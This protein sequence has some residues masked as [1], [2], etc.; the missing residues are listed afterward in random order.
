MIENLHCGTLGQANQALYIPFGQEVKL[1]GLQETNL[2][3]YMP[4]LTEEGKADT[5]EALRSSILKMNM[6]ELQ[7]DDRKH[8]KHSEDQWEKFF[9][10]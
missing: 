5:E 9:G 1:I 6:S 10:S 3:L 7:A 2:T 8:I 4:F